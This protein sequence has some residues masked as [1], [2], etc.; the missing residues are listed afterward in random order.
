MLYPICPSYQKAKDSSLKRSV[1]IRV[2]R[3]GECNISQGVLLGETIYPKDVWQGGAKY[4]RISSVGVPKGGGR[5]LS[6]PESF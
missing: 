3:D 5:V 4:P 6:S 1:L 2:A